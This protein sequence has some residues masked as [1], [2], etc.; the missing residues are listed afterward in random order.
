M[1]KEVKQGLV[2]IIV[3]SYNHVKYLKQ[4]MDSLISQTYQDIEIL[5]IDDC[6]TENIVEVLRQYESHPKVKLI[7]RV[8]NGGGWVAINNQGIEI[9]SGEYVHFAQ[10]DDYSDPQQ[11]ERLVN[12]MIA[13]P[14]AG[15]AFSRSLLVDEDNKSL[16]DDLAAR[17]KAFREKCSKDTLI[18]GKE[19]SRFLLHSCVIPNLSAALIR[20]NCFDTIGNFT[21]PYKVCGDWEWFF[22]VASRFDIAYVAEPLNK[23]RQH[24]FTIRSVTKSRLTFEEYFRILLSQIRLLD[25]TFSERCRFRIHVMQL[26]AVHL[27]AP[28]FDGLLN[29]YYHLKVVSSADPIAIIFLPIGMVK[30]IV[31]LF[32]SVPRKLFK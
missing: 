17:E 6:S 31:G 23:F 1:S 22:R 20:Q 24:R 14:T 13:N 28:S 8:K 16:G 27:L 4:R 10:C 25:L 15:I 26:W 12:A 9:S 2:S 5:V 29:F 7:L 11:I 18:T 3:P 19:M 30:R 32:G 21:T